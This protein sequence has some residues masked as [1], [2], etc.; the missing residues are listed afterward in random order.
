VPLRRHD[1]TS[2]HPV[3]QHRMDK[4]PQAASSV[5]TVKHF[6]AIAQSQMVSLIRLDIMTPLPIVDNV[7][8]RA[9][10]VDAHSE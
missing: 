5:Q 9:L 4:M 10:H 7:P 3:K 1:F 6:I 8:K 2:F